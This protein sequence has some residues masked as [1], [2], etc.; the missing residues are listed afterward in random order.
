MQAF[1]IIAADQSHD[2]HEKRTL[3]FMY[4]MGRVDSTMINTIHI[5]GDSIMKGILL[6]PVKE[7][8]YTITSHGAR[9]IEK[10]FG[11]HITNTSLFGCT[12]TKGMQLFERARNRG[13]NTDVVLLEFG[14]NDCDFNWKDVAEDPHAEHTP[15]TPLELFETTFHLLIDHIK[16][17]NIRPLMMTIPPIHAGRYLQWISHYGPDKNRILEFLRGDVQNIA[18]FQESYSE[19]VRVIAQKTNT[20]LVDVR[21]RFTGA[22]NYASLLCEDGIHPNEQ[23][24]RVMTDAF[25]DFASDYVARDLKA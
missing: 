22:G 14:G 1:L 7:H 2:Y 21:S 5:F 4:E 8:Y 23:G 9:W 12:I 13:L 20:L 18:K 10:Q 6:D 15:N 16:S 24:H 3:A 11:F 25:M 19:A 17:M